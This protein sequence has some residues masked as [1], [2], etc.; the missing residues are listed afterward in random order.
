M[1]FTHRL[2]VFRIAGTDICSA[3][4]KIRVCASMAKW[5][6]FQDLLHC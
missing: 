5:Q 4:Q 3:T 2:S 6:K 1:R